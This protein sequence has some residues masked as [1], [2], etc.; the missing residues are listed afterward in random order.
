M[1]FDD[2]TDLERFA[3]SLRHVQPTPTPIATLWDFQS[4]LMS[5]TT[6]DAA[7][8]SVSV[9]EVAQ[10]PGEFRASLSRRHLAITSS[11]NPSCTS[12]WNTRLLMGIRVG[13]LS[14]NTL[15]TVFRSQSNSAAILRTVEVSMVLLA[16]TH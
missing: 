9:A 1:K 12:F 10:R 15:Q 2:A 8:I 3:A 7:P 6:M 5:I 11:R 16:I 13:A 4:T 14:L